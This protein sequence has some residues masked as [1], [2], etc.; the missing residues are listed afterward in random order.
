M[1]NGAPSVA[2]SPQEGVAAA[3]PPLGAASS[4]E[5]GAG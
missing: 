4:S 3:K 1:I 5:H 2:S